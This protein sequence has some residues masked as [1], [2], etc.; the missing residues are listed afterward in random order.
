M[1]GEL[2]RD[3]RFWVAV[4]LLIK[5]VVFYAAPG[6]PPEVWAAVDGVLAVVIGAMAG[7]S[8]RMTVGR[9]PGRG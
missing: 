7:R 2:V 5:T 9:R 6:F 4:V 3:A 1:W 8:A